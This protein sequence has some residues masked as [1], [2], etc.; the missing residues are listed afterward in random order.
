MPGASNVPSGNVANV[1]LLQTSL[2]FSP[3]TIAPSVETEVTATLNGI[4]VNDYVNV[5]KPATQTYISIGNVRVS[6]NNVIAIN[7]S[8]DSTATMTPTTTDVYTIMVLRGANPSTLPP[9]IE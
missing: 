3:A 6:A 4:L 8:N 2:A 7:F 5:S 1:F 9:A